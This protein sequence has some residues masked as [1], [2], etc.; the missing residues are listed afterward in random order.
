MK[1]NTWVWRKA[2]LFLALTADLLDGGIWLGFAQKG[3][4][5][6]KDG[7]IRASY[8]TAEGLGKGN[9]RHFHLDREGALW[10]STDGSFSRLKNGHIATLTMKNGLPCDGIHWALEDDA[11]W[12]WLSTA[13]G[14]VRIQRSQLDAWAASVDKSRDSSRMV[15]A[16]VLDESDGVKISARGGFLSPQ[17]AKA[18]EGKLWFASVE[19]VNVIDPLHFPFNKLPPPVHVESVKIDGKEMAA[20]TDGFKLASKTH[21]VEIDYTALSFTEPDRMHFRY[22]LE[23][24]SVSDWQDVGTRR[25]AYFNDLKPKRYTFRVM[26]SN[27]D[28]VWNE[29]GAVWNFSVA[30]AFY[31]TLWF[32][33]LAVVAG[34]ALIWVL[35]RLRLRQATARVN[36]LYTERLAERS[37]IARDLHDTLL[38]SLAGVSL[39]LDGISKQAAKWPEKTPGPIS[40]VRDQVDACFR[41]ARG[42]VWDLRSP[43]LELY[44]LE[45]ALRELVER[46]GATTTARCEFTV[47][48]RARTCAPDVEEELLRLAQEA[49][50]NANRHAQASEIRVALEYG[51]NSLTLSISD[52][53]KG[54]DFEEGYGKSGHWGLKNMQERAAQI[55]GRCKVVTAAGQ[56][57]HI[58]VRVPLASSRL[59]KALTK[60]ANSS[61]AD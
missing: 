6:N 51:G 39:Q 35:Y 52:D 25:Q 46:I 13:C 47:T 55:G 5:Y 2:T 27:N 53:G 4:A 18:P 14:L 21:D 49:A 58:E 38:Q 26:A 59:K 22:K 23:G 61:S 28:G 50:N 43:E 7:Q 15:Q 37:R 30:P 32:G 33:G 36:L 8:S 9:V 56:G 19:G 29:A 44:G 17:A 3:V 10:L 16:T 40:R 48:G 1:L 20:P 54:F 12:F 45:A 42:K 60:H 31:Q 34:A 57:T 11:G 41:E 24:S